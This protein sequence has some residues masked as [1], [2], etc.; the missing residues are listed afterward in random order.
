MRHRR[1]GRTLGRSPSHQR[2]LL[3]NLASALML[4]ERDVEPDEPGAA[5][6]KGRIVTTLAK[7]KEVRPLVERCI[8]IARR[9][10]AAAARAGEFDSTAER[11]TEAW[12]EWRAS[13]RWREW[14]QAMAPAVKA[15][16]RVIQLLGDKQAAR[17][18]FEEIA[19][20]YMRSPRRLHPDPPAGPT[21]AGRCRP[22][23]DPGVCQW[24][25]RPRQ[26]RPRSWRRPRAEL[27][28]ARLHSV[29]GDWG[30]RSGRT[31]GPGNRPLL[32]RRIASAEVGPRAGGLRNVF[33]G[34]CHGSPEAVGLSGPRSWR[35]RGPC[36]ARLS[37][38]VGRVRALRHPA[39]QVHQ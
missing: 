3:R 18:V 9:G 27:S 34:G 2:A 8:T 4:T 11:G 17:V 16:R 25:E 24:R 21:A 39:G 35:R 29:T 7:A 33:P 38:P 31:S 10:L 1:K 36:R 20:R 32:C 5:K 12:R 15:R 30:A 14:A 22:A 6:V 28:G 26:H 37:G 19:P 13:P 23:G